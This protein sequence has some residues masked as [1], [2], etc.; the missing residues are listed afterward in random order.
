MDTALQV[1]IINKWN[2]NYVNLASIQTAVRP[3]PVLLG[4]EVVQV[5]D[6]LSK[7]GSKDR[8]AFEMLPTRYLEYLG[9]LQINLGYV[10]VFSCN[11]LERQVNLFDT[12]GEWAFA[13]HAISYLERK[14][15]ATLNCLMVGGPRGCRDIDVKSILRFSEVQ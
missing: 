13:F 1:E 9:I 4:T 15:V 5:G 10:L 11:W 14:G 8:T 2:A 7:I 6:R 12:P 3:I